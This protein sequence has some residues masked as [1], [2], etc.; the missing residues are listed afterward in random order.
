MA[1][2]AKDDPVPLI[3]AGVAC[4]TASPTRWVIEDP[5]SLLD[6]EVVVVLV[7]CCPGWAGVDDE[8]T[9][10]LVETPAVVVVVEVLVVVAV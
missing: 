8:G 10:P 6:T 9:V 5:V 3:W 1:G 2:A 7:D 4:G